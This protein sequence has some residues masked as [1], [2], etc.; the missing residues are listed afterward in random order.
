LVE[1]PKDKDD[2]PKATG[3]IGFI[4]I[5][6]AGSTSTAPAYKLKVSSSC[7]GTF[8]EWISFRKVIAELW[9]QN[10]LSNTQV[11]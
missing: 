8:A 7:E 2:K 11:G 4:L 1:E 5:Q 10:G 9:R 3:L 6:R